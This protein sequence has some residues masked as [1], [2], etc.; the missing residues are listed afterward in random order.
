[1]TDNREALLQKVEEAKAKILSLLLDTPSSPEARDALDNFAETLQVSKDLQ[2]AIDNLGMNI[3]RTV[4]ATK[5]PENQ[6]KALLIKV[7]NEIL[8]QATSG[9]ATALGVM[10]A[11]MDRVDDTSRNCFEMLKENQEALEAQGIQV[12]ATDPEEVV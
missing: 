10:Q 4:C 8:D 9:M 3:V 6:S 11:A 1:M 5:H 2:K 7:S 12:D